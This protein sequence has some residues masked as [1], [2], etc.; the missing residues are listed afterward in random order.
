M[1][2]LQVSQECEEFQ[3]EDKVSVFG[4]AAGPASPPSQDTAV[5]ETQPAL[6]G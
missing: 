3:Q 1:Q 5:G 2:P 6:S 4:V